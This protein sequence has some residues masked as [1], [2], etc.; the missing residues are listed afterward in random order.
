MKTINI[1]NKSLY[2][3]QHNDTYFIYDIN[4]MDIYHISYEEYHKVMKMQNLDE[5]S[6]FLDEIMKND[7]DYESII[8]SK[9]QYENIPLHSIAIEVSNDCNLR[10]KYCYGDGGTYGGEKCLMST[11]TA[12]KCVDFLLSNSNNAKKLSIIFFGGEPLMNF[13][14]IKDTVNYCK[15]ISKEKNIDFSFGMTTNATLLDEDKATFFK[16][17][18]FFITVSIDGPKN[19]HDKNR[20]FINKLGSYDLVELGVNLMLKKNIRMRARAT[21][22]N[23]Y[24]K[25]SQ[26]EQHFESIGFTDIVLSFVDTDKSSDLYIPESRF[27]EIYNEIDKL[28]EKCMAQLQYHGDTK[29]NMFRT[30]LER[31]Y[32]HRPAVRS[33]G[34]GTTYLAFT[35]EGDLYPCHRFSNWKEY[36]LGNY[37]HTKINNQSFINCSILKR[38][39]CKNCFGKFICGGNCMHSSAF[40]GESIFDTDT[41][42]CEI[43]RKIMQTSIYIYYNAKNSNPDVFVNLFDK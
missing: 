11:E 7:I 38:D 32:H 39:K 35:S 33:C 30:I 28:G 21:I 6:D 31:L 29:I 36:Y 14:V 25:L 22:N 8:D 34:A 19:I 3:F 18:D 42:Y 15:K 26:L 37:S 20:Y 27:T 10:C 13:S 43:L 1:H 41:H 9:P 24:L 4:S 16:E 2:L 23:S 40:F 17:N 5:I 12:I